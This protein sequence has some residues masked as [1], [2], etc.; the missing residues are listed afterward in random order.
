MNRSNGIQIAG[1]ENEANYSTGAQIAISNSAINVTGV[2]I[3][4]FNRCQTL[5]GIQLGL[6]NVNN[7][8]KLPIINWGW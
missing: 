6:W 3:G 5:R 1:V 7:K 2:Q 8:R 4:I